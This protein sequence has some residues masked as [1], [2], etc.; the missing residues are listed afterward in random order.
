MS[1]VIKLDRPIVVGTPLKSGTWLIRQIVSGIT[2]MSW[3]E[4]VMVKGIAP[5]DPDNIILKNDAFYSW[6]FIPEDDIQAKLV[7]N[8][9]YCIFVVR[10]IFAMTLSMYH[11]FSDNIDWELGKGANQVDLFAKL[12]KDQGIRRIIKREYDD[13]FN[14]QGIGL[15]FRQIQKMLEFTHAGHSMVLTFEKLVDDKLFCIQKIMEFLNI[16][17]SDMEIRTICQN[18]DFSVMKAHAKQLGGGSHFRSG[19]TR[20]YFNAISDDNKDLIM[21]E[22]ARSAPDLPEYAR[23]LGIS[24]IVDW[25]NCYV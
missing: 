4:P 5:T 8:N 2:G 25:N 19:L 6:H 7:C 11:H 13:G 23:M 17:L 14:W 3:F 20:G 15:Y 10:N 21:S 24:F 9:A 22:L 16:G 18:S 1:S 12:T